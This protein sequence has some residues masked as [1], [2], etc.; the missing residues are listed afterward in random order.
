MALSLWRDLAAHVT[1]PADHCCD[2][3]IRP[4]TKKALQYPARDVPEVLG[5]SSSRFVVEA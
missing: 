5:S 3:L 2:I 4:G 1:G